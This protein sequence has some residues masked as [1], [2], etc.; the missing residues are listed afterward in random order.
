MIII[1]LLLLLGIA[2]L[3]GSSPQLYDDDILMYKDDALL[4]YMGVIRSI[5]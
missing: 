2:I 5:E 3:S 4:S 1:Q